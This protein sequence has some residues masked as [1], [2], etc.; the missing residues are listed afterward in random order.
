MSM[1]MVPKI[2][3]NIKVGLYARAMANIMTPKPRKTP[4]ITEDLSGMS[5]EITQFRNSN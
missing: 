1:A 4:N 3:K 2:E 5:D